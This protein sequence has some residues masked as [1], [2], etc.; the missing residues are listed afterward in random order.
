MI[1]FYNNVQLKKEYTVL[2]NAVVAFMVINL[3]LMVY[4]IAYFKYFLAIGV[5]LDQRVKMPEVH[6]FT[7]YVKY[8]VISVMMLVLIIPIAVV[9]VP[10]QDC[11]E[12]FYSRDGSPECTDC[13]F[14]L[15]SAC[16]SCVG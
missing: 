13:K 15:G 9:V 4:E 16:N 12:G 2:E 5:N 3:M 11:Q 6:R 1:F 10:I 14:T 8:L 7:N